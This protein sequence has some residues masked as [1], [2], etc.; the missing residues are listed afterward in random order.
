[1]SWYGTPDQCPKDDSCY[2][3]YESTCKGTEEEGMV[4]K[5]KR[6]LMKWYVMEDLQD[7]MPYFE[8]GWH[9][10]VPLIIYR[11]RA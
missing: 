9:G 6:K 10:I 5:R 1:M 7:S 3:Y 8:I 4:C 2:E 11:D